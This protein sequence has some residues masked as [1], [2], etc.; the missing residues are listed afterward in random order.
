LNGASAIWWLSCRIGA[1][2]G[3]GFPAAPVDHTKEHSMAKHED[4]K[5]KPVEN[6]PVEN[7]TGENE[8][9]QNPSTGS[10]SGEKAS[11]A[12]PGQDVSG[13]APRSDRANQAGQPPSG[14]YQSPAAADQAQALHEGE[15]RQAAIQGSVSTQDR[16]NQGKRDNR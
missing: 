4:R 8:A 10:S 7:Q 6:E 16:H 9:D 15:T 3:S 2:R 5:N 1:I 12:G 11:R 13:K 14:G